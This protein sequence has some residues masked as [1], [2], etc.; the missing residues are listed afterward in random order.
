MSA[1][2]LCVTA[3][4]SA[5]DAV[6]GAP[7]DGV[8]KHEKMH[9]ERRGMRGG[10]FGRHG[11]F[12]GLRGIELTDAQKEQIRLI[13][14]SNKPDGKFMEEMKGIREARKAGTE[15]TPEQKA[16]LKAISE[17]SRAKRESVRQQVLAILTPEQLQKLE[18]LKTEREQKM[19]ERMEQRK[20][21]MELR[22]TK[23]PAGEK[24]AVN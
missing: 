19:K 1:A 10:K 3:A 16:R 9:H 8:E 7:K 12:P 11:G 21:R 22:K 2:T 6:K 23:T 14:E 17:E 13:H 24:P 4:V 15:I 5:Q 20:Q 18:T